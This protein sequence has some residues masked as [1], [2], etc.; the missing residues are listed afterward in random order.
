LQN[1]RTD[2]TA[3][4][5]SGGE[6]SRIGLNK[7]FLKIEGKSLIQR[8]IELL[9][10]VFAKV[11]IS[12]NERELYEFTR[13]KVINDI[14]PGRG[15]LSGIHSALECTD[16]TKNFIISC[17]LPLITIEMINYMV[18]Y[19]SQKEM[20]KAEGRIQQLC[21]IYSKNVLL[22]IEN[23]LVESNKSTSNLKGSIF[24]LMDRV[25]TEITE[26]DK[27]GFYHSNLF[28]NINSPEDYNLAKSILELK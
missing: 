20:P 12:S 19:S 24:E 7:A 16:T 5:L 3:F 27:L 22:E 1:H 2:I 18:N 15:P 8:L 11:I 25:Q 9:D 6:S 13:K 26:V 21:G 28:L 4:I 10:S 17:D 14:Y 23:L